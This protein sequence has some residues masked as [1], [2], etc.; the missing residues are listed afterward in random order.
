MDESND[1]KFAYLHGSTKRNLI[2]ALEDALEGKAAGDKVSIVVEAGNAY[3]ARDENKVQRVPKK[4]F[5][6]DQELQVGMPFSSATPDGTAVN[7]VITAIE[8][9]E[10]VV[11]GNHPLAG[12]DLNFDIELLE[13]RDA[14]DEE[15]ELG[16]THGPSGQ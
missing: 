13:V 8:E 6:Q 11:D 7:V 12:I 5:P 9:D 10:V 14:T 15:I 2:P 4:I 1:G 16:H 3:G